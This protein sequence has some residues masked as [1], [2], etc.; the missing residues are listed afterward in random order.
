MSRDRLL[1][2]PAQ[3][4]A[5]GGLWVYRLGNS[6]GE[7]SKALGELS[8]DIIAQSKTWASGIQCELGTTSL[9]LA[10]KFSCS[11]LR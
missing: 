7:W 1:G 4:M 11:G 6:R 5:T 2:V 8:P 10:M 9:T 3:V